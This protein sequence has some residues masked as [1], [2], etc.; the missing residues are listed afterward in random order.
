MNIK[1]LSIAAALCVMPLCGNAQNAGKYRRAYDSF[2][3]QSGEK[4]ND[5]RRKCNED[6][7]RFVENAW[8]SFRSEKPLPR[9]LP[10][11]P[12]PPVPFKDGGDSLRPQLRQLPHELVVPVPQPIPQPAPAEPIRE[13]P[14]PG[15]QPFGFSFYGTEAEVRLDEVQRITLSDCS[16]TGV[17]A[18]WRRYSDGS[19]DNAVRDCLSLR[20][21]HRL[22]DWAYLQMLLRLGSAFF[23]DGTDEATLLAAYIYCQSGYKMRLARGAGGRLCMLVASRHTIYD[24]GYFKIDGENYY[25]MGNKEN[26]L[27]IC[28]VSFPGEQPL[29][30]YI[31][32]ATSLAA[33]PSEP[34]TIQSERYPEIKARVSVNRNLL[35]L[36]NSYPASEV[37]GNFMTKW[38]MYANTPL[39]ENVRRELYPPLQQA[40]DGQS[41]LEAAQRL[42]NFVQTAFVYE[43]DEKVWGYDR[44]FFAEETLFYPYCDCEDRSIL[45][46][47]LVRDLLGLDVVL[48]YYPGHLAAAVGFTDDVNGD[49]ITLDGRHYTVCD[50]TYI[51]APVGATMP[52]MDNAKAKVIM[53]D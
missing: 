34:R 23:G 13:Q 52:G 18:A 50:P 38:A 53:L 26:S 9:P 46:S 31:T 27:D 3:K 11:K 24:T 14:S 28:N 44:A 22:S 12:V 48:I 7:A 6:Y 25:P 16:E 2:R 30:L 4:Y 45:F 39:D 36:Y 15:G 41:Q 35:D 51:G 8:Q 42:L 33:A 47:R 1:T 40:L 43:Y 17:A 21:K 19:Y 49:C 37:S 29:S 20:L 5:F 32:Q 10:D